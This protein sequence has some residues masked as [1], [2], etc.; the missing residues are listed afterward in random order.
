MYLYIQALFHAHDN[1]VDCLCYAVKHCL[2]ESFTKP[3]YFH[4][5]HKISILTKENPRIKISPMRAGGEIG[6]KFWFHNS[7]LNIPQWS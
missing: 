4:N 6:Q 1:N 2:V 5:T 7:K 3:S